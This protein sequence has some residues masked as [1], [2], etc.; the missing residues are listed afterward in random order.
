MEKISNKIAP[1]DYEVLYSWKLTKDIYIYIY[2]FFYMG[3]VSRTFTNYRIAEEG[4]GHFIISFQSLPPA[5][6][7]LRD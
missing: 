2:I 4:G 5:S 3:F 1:V 6:Q 7:T